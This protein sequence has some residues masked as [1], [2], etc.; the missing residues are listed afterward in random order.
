MPIQSQMRTIGATSVLPFGVVYVAV[1]ISQYNFV[2][3][4][5]P[6][7]SV[8]ETRERGTWMS[9]FSHKP[10]N[11]ELFKFSFNYLASLPIITAVHLW[12]TL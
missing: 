5:T 10:I 1:P 11:Y 2:K 3:F 12:I 9:S 8:K 7:L 4:L 6:F